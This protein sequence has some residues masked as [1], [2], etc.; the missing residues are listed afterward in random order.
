MA[1]AP[2]TVDLT[3][4]DREPI[5]LLGAIQPFGFLVTIESANWTI[6]RASRNAAE[7]LQADSGGLLGRPLD[8]FF[9]HDGLHLIRGHLQ[10]A[11]FTNTATHGHD[12]AGKVVSVWLRA[13]PAGSGLELCYEDDGPAFD[14]TD[15]APDAAEAQVS[16][17]HIG[18]LGRALVLFLPN[19]IRYEHNDGHNR[20][21][22]HFAAAGDAE[23]AATPA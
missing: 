13:H 3:N 23:D 1:D 5:H 11:M 8:H 21:H 22:M 2:A 17:W 4:C 7:W 12:A 16:R 10:T 19:R 18:G 6:T 14:P 9:T 20:L 15:I